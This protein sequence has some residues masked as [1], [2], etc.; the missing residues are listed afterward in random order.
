MSISVQYETLLTNGSKECMT[1]E[2]TGDVLTGG[3][4]VRSFQNPSDEDCTKTH[5]VICIEE[6]TNITSR[7]FY[8]D[9]RTT[10]TNA[11]SRCYQQTGY[12]ISTDLDCTAQSNSALNTLEKA[13]LGIFRRHY[14]FTISKQTD[15]LST[16]A[17]IH[18]IAATVDNTGKLHLSNHDC[19]TSL[20]VWCMSQPIISSSS[21]SPMSSSTTTPKITMTSTIQ[22]IITNSIQVVTSDTQDTSLLITIS[23]LATVLGV[24]ILIAIV[25]LIR[26]ILQSRQTQ[27]NVSIKRTTPNRRRPIQANN[28]TSH[29][30]DTLDS[31]YEDNIYSVIIT[32][33]EET[34]RYSEIYDDIENNE[35]EKTSSVKYVNTL[36]SSDETTVS[37]TSQQMENP[38]YLEIISQEPQNIS[39]ETVLDS[40]S[41]DTDSL[42]KVSY[43]NT[44]NEESS[45][46]SAAHV[47]AD[48]KEH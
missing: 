45:R 23:V 44:K 27:S 35:P 42:S 26:K 28:A 34:P 18:C 16:Q 15:I 3:T 13:W 9:P 31:I 22:S 48:E 5:G 39:N 36:P 19:Q 12:Q 8:N 17:N 1:V 38:E 32:N 37:V 2:Y 41:Q 4:T 10:W 25:I 33:D 14:N 40:D 43:E 20:P 30:E 24:G 11:V 21:T 47:S 6:G 29:Y 46:I 7:M